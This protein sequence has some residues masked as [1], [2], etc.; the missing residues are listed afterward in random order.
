MSTRHLTLPLTACLALVLT[1]CAA[2]STRTMGAGPSTGCHAAGAASLL[3][4]PLDEPVLMQALRD[5]GALRS[6]V[7]PAG[8]A[9]IAGSA[10]PMRLNIQLDAQGHIHRMVCG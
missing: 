4:Q 8:A 3:G 1:A 5:S 6:R 2:P 10:D 7:L 9:A